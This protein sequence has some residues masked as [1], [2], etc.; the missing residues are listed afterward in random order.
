MEETAASTCS[1]LGHCSGDTSCHTVGTLKQPQGEVTRGG[2]EASVD[3]QQSTHTHVDKHH[4]N[5]C[6][7]PSLQLK[8][9]PRTAW[10][11]GGDTKPEPLSWVASE[12]STRRK[13]ARY[14]L[15]VCCAVLRH[16]LRGWAA[17]QQRKANTYNTPFIEQSTLPTNLRWHFFYTK[18]LYECG[19]SLDF[20][21]CPTDL[22]HWSNLTIQG[23]KFGT[24]QF[25]PTIFH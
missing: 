23:F 15:L 22:F 13:H 2:T 6:P 7:S 20:P 16:K 18:F 17:L 24:G 5:R 19:S 25:L 1:L 8:P 10:S 14:L 3:G 4:G 11:R 12:F 21:L 9:Q